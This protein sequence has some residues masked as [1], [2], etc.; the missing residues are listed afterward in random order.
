MTAL[1]V[2]T[3]LGGGMSSALFQKIREEKGL[4][5]TVY[6][7]LDLYRDAGIFGTY[8]AT[9]KTNLEQAL[10]ITLKELDKVKKRKLPESKLDLIKAQLKGH[11]TLG[12]ESTSS[13]MSRLARTE[14][15]LGTYHPLKHTLGLID[16]V[17]PESFLEMVNN[18]IDNSQLAISVLGPAEKKVIENVI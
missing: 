1:A 9:D 18:I 3:Y 17:T 5:Y 8:L 10:V 4:A 2:H 14:L 11:L 13:R 6:T 12:M 16:K 7:Y 15:M